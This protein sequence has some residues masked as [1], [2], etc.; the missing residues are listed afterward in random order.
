MTRRFYIHPEDPQQRLLEQ[1]ARMLEKGGIIA[2]PTDAAYTLGCHMGD[3]AALDRIRQMRHL[4]K[5]HLFTLL[6]KDLA[7]I[8]TYAKLNN[9]QFRFLKAHTPGPYT[10]IL[11]ATK[12]VPK[13]L[14]NPKRRTVGIRVPDNK[15][16]HALLGLLDQ[17][18]M[19]ATCKSIGMDNPYTDPEDIYEAFE[20]QFD[21]LIIG[22]NGTID[23]TTVIDMV[24]S[25]P[26][27]IR[28][29]LGIL[30]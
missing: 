10:F 26:T 19:T 9:Q 21:A 22:E 30:K 17:P 18:L 4:P 25:E 23:P 28:Q 6:C 7:D 13:R 27:L 12:E 29:G 15:I 5:D 1:A 8:A 16:T 2:L 24:E 14:Q 11:Q 20:D 3:K